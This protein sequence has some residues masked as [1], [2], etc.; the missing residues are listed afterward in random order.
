MRYSYRILLKEIELVW[1]KPCSR[2]VFEV[3]VKAN[4]AFGCDK[5][6]HMKYKEN[7]I[8]IYLYNYKT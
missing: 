2:H 6:F 3:L 8:I 7:F 1:N 5:K 4:N